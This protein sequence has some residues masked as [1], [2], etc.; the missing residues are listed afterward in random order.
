MN[1]IFK[2]I[3]AFCHAFAV[4]FLRVT[5]IAAELGDLAGVTGLSSSAATL[6]L[7]TSSN[8]GR[9]QAE[10]QQGSKQEHDTA[11]HGVVLG[12]SWLYLDISIVTL[13]S[14]HTLCVM[15]QL[16][17]QTSHQLILF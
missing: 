8:G 3:N 15:L 17:V 6:A 14:K 10:H 1:F 12:V 7:P 5:T 4:R 9:A 13:I 2:S 16:T 11:R